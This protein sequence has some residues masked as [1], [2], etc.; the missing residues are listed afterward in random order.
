MEEE[1]SLLLRLSQAPDEPKTPVRQSIK[2][3]Y[4]LHSPDSKHTL[5]KIQKK[6]DTLLTITYMDDSN[7]LLTIDCKKGERKQ[8]FLERLRSKIQAASAV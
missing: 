6:S 3:A 2:T 7:K 4:A 8:Q 5:R 1:A